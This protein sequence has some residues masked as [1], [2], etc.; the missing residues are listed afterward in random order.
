MMRVT[1][2]STEISAPISRSFAALT[3]MAEICINNIQHDEEN[4]IVEIPLKRRVVIKQKRKG[5]LGLFLPNYI[6]GYKW[7]DAVLIIRQ[8]AKMNLDVD[9]LLITD[10]NSCF[11]AMMGLKLDKH[12]LYLGSVEETAGKT[13]CQIFVKVNEF[14]LELVDLTHL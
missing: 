2:E 4:G 3:D 7:F 14:D 11:S 13:L 12:E 1:F 5:Y 10:C 6:A 9:D 8:V